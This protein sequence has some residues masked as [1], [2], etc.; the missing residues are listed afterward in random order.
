MGG[1]VALARTTEAVKFQ[2]AMEQVLLLDLVCRA[3]G[4]L[5]SAELV[6]DVQSKLSLVTLLQGKAVLAVAA[7]DGI[8][9]NLGGGLEVAVLSDNVLAGD[10]E[11][12]VLN[13]A[14]SS[15]ASREVGDLNL[16][17][18]RKGNSAEK[19]DSGGDGELHFDFGKGFVVCEKG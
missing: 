19:G 16:L 8:S 14:V 4:N 18:I 17:V 13:G 5:P 1:N 10:L 11:L 9:R 2:L 7:S 15:L 6:V 3:S 12:G